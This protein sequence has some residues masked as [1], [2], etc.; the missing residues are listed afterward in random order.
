MDAIAKLEEIVALSGPTPERL[1]LLGGRYKRLFTSAK[2][3]DKAEFLD[4]AIDAYERG[5]EIDLNQY[6]CSC[7]PAAPLPSAQARWRRSPSRHRRQGGARRLRESREAWPCGRVAEATLL[8]AA[9]DAREYEK[10]EKLAAEFKSKPGERWKNASTIGDLELSANP[11]EN[12]ETKDRLT[13]ILEPLR[14]AVT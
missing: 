13:A 12:K 7:K 14:A 5:M 10:A 2:D 8:G 11:A 1:G 9:F 6:Y 4:S 3:E